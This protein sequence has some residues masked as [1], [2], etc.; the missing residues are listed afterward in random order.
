MQDLD[1]APPDLAIPEGL[2]IFDLSFHPFAHVLAVGLIDGTV[3]LYQTMTE[4]NHL[5]GSLKAHE[6]ASRAVC[7]SRDGQVLYSVAS[8]GSVDSFAVQNGDIVTNGHAKNVRNEAV[9]AVTTCTPE[10]I[11][12]GDDSGRVALWDVRTLGAQAKPALLFHEN[13]DF[14]SDIV[15]DAGSKCL[16]ATGGDGC[17]SVFNVRKGKHLST[18]DSFDDEF[19]SCTIV[20]Q[21]TSD[22]LG[23]QGDAAGRLICGTQEGSLNSFAWG[24]WGYWRERLADAHPFSVETL[25]TVGPNCIASGAGDGLVRI[26][27]VTPLEVVEVIGDHGEYPVECMSISHDGSFLASCSHDSAIKFWDV[28]QFAEGKINDLAAKK[29]RVYTE[30]NEPEISERKREKMPKSSA[31]EKKR[32]NFFKGLM[33]DDEDSDL[34]EEDDVVME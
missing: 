22:T 21:G 25:V 5:V 18:S 27:R 34:D 16:C 4:G 24:Y 2:Q 3:Q 9:N 7:F 29:E 1:C 32:R 10:L 19:L 30:E 13:T 17:L 15:Y 14:I 23:G 12:T 28:R 26:L 6:S 33:E 20:R 31:N 11:A 8:D